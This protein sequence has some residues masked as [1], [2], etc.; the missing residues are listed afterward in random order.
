M[1]AI[2]CLASCISR[3]GASLDLALDQTC[4]GGTITNM[5]DITTGTVGPPIT[6]SCIK[7]VDVPEMGYLT[8]DVD[9]QTG[10]VMP[11]RFKMA[12]RVDTRAHVVSFFF[13]IVKCACL[14]GWV[15]VSVGGGNAWRTLV[16][17]DVF[18]CAL[19]NVAAR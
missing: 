14:V 3:T 8:T 6:C 15:A 1:V 19:F 10:R 9:E 11:V 18:V 5:E 12:T 16:R 4:G 7:L 2:A 17:T 13:S